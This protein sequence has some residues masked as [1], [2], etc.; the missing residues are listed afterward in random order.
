MVMVVFLP[1]TDGDLPEV[2]MSRRIGCA[3]SV[4][5]SS[6]GVDDRVTLRLD[7]LAGAI[8]AVLPS[9]VDAEE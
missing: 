7:A 8:I 6:E 4:G 2:F 9:V 3:G 1:I 5:A